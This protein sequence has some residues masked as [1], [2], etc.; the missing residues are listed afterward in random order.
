MSGISRLRARLRISPKP[1]LGVQALVSLEIEG[2]F[3]S[4]G[5]D[6]ELLFDAEM[7]GILPQQ[8]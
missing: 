1:P 5:I 2:N 4:M 7:T 8:A 3:E 6:P